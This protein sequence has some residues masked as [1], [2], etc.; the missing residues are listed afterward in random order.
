MQS[1]KLTSRWLSSNISVHSCKDL[2]WIFSSF[3]NF[4]IAMQHDP[5]DKWYW[6]YAVLSSFYRLCAKCC[7]F[8]P[9]NR[10]FARC[11]SIVHWLIWLSNFSF[12]Y[13][14]V[15]WVDI[16]LSICDVDYL[17]IF[18]LQCP[19][20]SIM[21]KVSLYKYYKNTNSLRTEHIYR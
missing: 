10:C 18:S 13:N 8:W 14:G 21:P 16:V 17:Q 2:I 19:V 7:V 6:S 1:C 9:V 15:Y 20:P 4:P 11:S 3:F 5:L 12:S